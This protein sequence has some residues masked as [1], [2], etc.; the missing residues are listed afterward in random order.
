MKSRR[1]ERV[2]R[3]AKPV[4][5]KGFAIGGEQEG[6]FFGW[7]PNGC[8]GTHVR[9][10]HRLLVER[11]ASPRTGDKTGLNTSEKRKKKASAAGATE[12]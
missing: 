7:L 12:A 10:P 6:G 3:S 4:T 1:F 8:I 2:A 11:L 5:I 9:A